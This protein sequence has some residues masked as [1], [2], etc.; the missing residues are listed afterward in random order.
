MSVLNWV[1]ENAA[2]RLGSQKITVLVRNGLNREYRVDSSVCRDYRAAQIERDC[3]V[4]MRKVE[5]H[6]S[7]E[8]DELEAGGKRGIPNACKQKLFICGELKRL[9]IG[10]ACARVEECLK[11][12]RIGSLSLRYVIDGD[13]VVFVLLFIMINEFFK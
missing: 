6:R 2:A 5:S 8:H 1:K 7:V 4:W 11:S 10:V 12:Q 3:T 13:R 9:A